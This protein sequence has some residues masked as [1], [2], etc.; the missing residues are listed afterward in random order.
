[1]G[2]LTNG[3]VCYQTRQD[4]MRLFSVL[5][6]RSDI[7]AIALIFVEVVR[8][9][10]YDAGELNINKTLSSFLNGCFCTFNYFELPLKK[11]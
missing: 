2:L 7:E 4:M 11:I 5:H 8:E 9:D 10:R 3:E 1:M 6:F